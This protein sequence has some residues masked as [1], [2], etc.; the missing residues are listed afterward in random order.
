MYYLIQKF[1]HESLIEDVLEGD[2]L[3]HAVE[4]AFNDPKRDGYNILGNDVEDTGMSVQ[5]MLDWILN[6][7]NYEFTSIHTS[8]TPINSL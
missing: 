8:H 4:N 5:D 6:D 2:T 3:K 7:E 1:E